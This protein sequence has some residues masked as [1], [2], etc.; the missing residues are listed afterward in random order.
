MVDLVNTFKEKYEYPEHF[1]NDITSSVYTFSNQ[2]GESLG[3]IYGGFISQNY[4]FEFAC[5]FTGLLNL[6]FF[7]FFFNLYKKYMNL[8][9]SEN[10]DIQKLYL[11]EL[12]EKE[13]KHSEDSQINIKAKLI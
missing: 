3:P 2:L 4:G 1:A 13:D 9:K 5:I 10:E 6:I 7:S 12:P 11:I 8:K